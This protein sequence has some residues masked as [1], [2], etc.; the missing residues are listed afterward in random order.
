MGGE[1]SGIANDTSTVFLEGAFWNPAV[2][3][4]KMRRLGFQSDA[5][6]R[7]ERGVDFELGPRARRA[8][9]AADPRDLRRTR[10]SADRCEGRA[11]RRVR[12]CACAP[13]ASTRL[14]G[15]AL[16]PADDRR[17][18]HAAQLPFTR[19]RRRL[20]RHAAVLSLRSRDRG[21]LRRGGRANPRLRRDPGRAARARADDAAAPES[22]RCAFTLKRRARR[23]RL[24]GGD[25]VQLRL[26]RR[27]ARARSPARAPDRG[28]ESDRQ[29]I[30]T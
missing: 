2:I 8:R 23:A 17:R 14:L 7:F 18:V 10:R 24:A 28:A 1:H 11:A 30:S 22:Q 27:R 16:S 4:G 15:V 6:Y 25:H 26:L 13:R 19:E 20:H 9:D 21:G 5:G 29:R 3:Q 12:R